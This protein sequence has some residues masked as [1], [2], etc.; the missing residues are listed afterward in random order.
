MAWLLAIYLNLATIWFLAPDQRYVALPALA[1]ADIGIF[2]LVVLWNRDGAFPFFELG[3]LTILA[4][5]A[6]ALIPLLGYFGS[7]MNFTVLS[8][9]RL[10]SLDATYKDMGALAWRYAIYLFSFAAVYLIWRG[11]SSALSSPLK[12]P[13]RST[14]FTM[15]TL[16]LTL[17]FL[18]LIIYSIYGYNF[19]YSYEDLAAVKKSLKLMPLLLQQAS[20]HLFGVFILL[21]LALVI[22][23]VNYW[24]IKRWRYTLYIWLFLEF[25]LTV[26]Q[27]GARTWL[28]YLLVAVPLVYHRLVKPLK[29]SAVGLLGSIILTGLLLYGVIRDQYYYSP[30]MRITEVVTTGSLFSVSNEFQVMW[31]NAYHLLRMKEIGSLGNI[32]VALYLCDILKFIPQQLLPFPKV[33]PSEWYLELIG[34]KESGTGLMFGVLAHAVIGLDWM[35]LVLRGALLGYIF[36]LI[37]R[38]Y[39]RRSSS[40]WITLLY[41]WLCIFSYY[42]VRAGT[43]YFASVTF[44]RF[45]I[46][47]FLVKFGKILLLISRKVVTAQAR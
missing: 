45:I 41:L 46:L 12:V 22:I 13:D 21:K 15:V 9:H 3:S 14:V 42:T 43:F 38:W 18:F 1:I 29:L 25:L 20:L 7:G 47:I 4:T 37:H 27:M 28:A 6:Y 10:F 35:E 31:G 17:L 39:V 44:H 30:E 2:S 5:L 40:F 33:E 36:A 26:T 8:D 11:D 16:I 23:L 32:P 19:W 24:H 34:Q